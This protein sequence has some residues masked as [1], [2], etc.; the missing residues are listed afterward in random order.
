MMSMRERATQ[1]E[2][3]IKAIDEQTAKLQAGR[4]RA[5][6]ALMLARQV[7][8]EEDAIPKMQEL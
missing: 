4:F 2:E 7:I 6:G 1:I 3:Q 8:A 5:E